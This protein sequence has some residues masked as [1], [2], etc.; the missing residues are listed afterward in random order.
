MNK[1]S[2]KSESHQNKIL[3]VGIVAMIVMVGIVIIVQNSI[4][5]NVTSE[6]F[7]NKCTR[8][9]PDITLSRP[10]CEAEGYKE[11]AEKNPLWQYP[12]SKPSICYKQCVRTVKDICRKNA[13][14]SYPHLN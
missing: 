9:I 2:K 7:M 5:A 13:P 4:T 14:F 10:L 6:E 3:I 1:K 11:C 8:V 12:M